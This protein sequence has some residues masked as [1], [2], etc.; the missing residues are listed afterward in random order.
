MRRL[1]DFHLMVSFVLASFFLAFDAEAGEIKGLG[2]RCIDVQGGISTNGSPVQ[3]YACHHGENQNWKLTDAGEI[4]IFSSKCLDIR[5]GQPQPSPGTPVQI[6]DCH[7]G[8][9]QHWDLLEGVIRG[10]GGCL[11]VRGGVSADGTPLQIFPCHGGE[12]QHWQFVGRTINVTFYID[13]IAVDATNDSGL[14]NTADEIYI[15]SRGAVPAPGGLISERLPRHPDGDDYYKF[16]FPVGEPF[17][18]NNEE[19]GSVAHAENHANWINYSGAPVGRPV[20]WSGSLAH[21]Q[22]S[23][24]V[25][26]FGEQDNKDAALLKQVIL[27]TLQALGGIAVPLAGQRH[28]SS[29]PQSRARR[30]WPTIYRQIRRTMWSVRSLCAL[31]IMTVN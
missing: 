4:R 30:R 25:I 13:Q 28:P 27:G 24:F 8:P 12:N 14:G 19:G 15:L 16:R 2:G 3:L 26:I 23:E 11:D 18:F 22:S 21:N 29:P 6:Y 10:L 7:D 17:P 9:N 1:I 31:S 5:G 20:F